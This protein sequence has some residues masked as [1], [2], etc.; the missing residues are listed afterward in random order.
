M[1]RILGGIGEYNRSFEATENI[2]ALEY[3]PDSLLCLVPCAEWSS[4]FGMGS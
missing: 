3:D 1:A 4:E 2:R